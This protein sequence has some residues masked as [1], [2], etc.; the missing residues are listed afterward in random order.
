MSNFKELLDF[1][2]QNQIDFAKCENVALAIGKLV[3][4]E[5]I[6]KTKKIPLKPIERTENQ[7]LALQNQDYKVVF[8]KSLFLRSFKGIPQI[9]LK[10]IERTENQVLALQNQDYKVVF[11]KSLKTA[12]RLVVGLGSTHVLETSL[13]LH[14]IFGIPYIPGTALKGVVRMVSF[15][16]IAKEEKKLEDLQKQLYEGKLSSSE[17]EDRIKHKL[18]FGTQGFKGLLVFLDAYPEISENEEIFELD[19]MNVHYKSYYGDSSG[20]TP[21]GDWENPN[22]ITFLTVKKGIPFRF[23]VL[24]DEFRAKR[25]LEDKDIPEKHKG[26]LEGWINNPDNLENLLKGWIESALKEFGVGAK[27]RLGYGIFE[28]DL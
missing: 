20:K 18:L 24:F 9:P 2:Y 1:L 26:M 6:D 22:P 4:M 12:Y 10:P 11:N 17:N 27:T 25:I 5:I 23:Y 14:H 8:N 7:V 3:K 13:T 16:E 15:W 28:G 19:I 21:P